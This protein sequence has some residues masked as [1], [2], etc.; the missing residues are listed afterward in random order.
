MPWYHIVC[1]DTT[2]PY[3]KYEQQKNRSSHKQIFR[4]PKL[5]SEKNCTVPDE[6]TYK[7]ATTGETNTTHTNSITILGDIKSD[8]WY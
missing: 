2:N 1:R 7:E 8:I 6:K 5:L 4:K 3:S